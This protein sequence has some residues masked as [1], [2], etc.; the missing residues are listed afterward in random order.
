MP[1]ASRLQAAPTA[2]GAAHLPKRHTRPLSQGE[3]ALHATPSGWGA[4]H[5]APAQTRLPSQSLLVAHGAPVLPRCT[6]LPQPVPAV[7]RQ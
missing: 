6:Q 2:P 7:I 4:A 1:P 5:A 3:V